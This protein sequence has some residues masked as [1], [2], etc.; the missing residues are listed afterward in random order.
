MQPSIYSTQAD[1]PSIKHKYQVSID[2]LHF[3]LE[4]ARSRLDLRLVQQLND[5][6]IYLQ[7]QL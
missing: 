5:E 3:R 7:N 4:A 2:K 1:S 6:L